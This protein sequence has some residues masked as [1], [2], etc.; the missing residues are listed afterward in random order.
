MCRDGDLA[1]IGI[2]CLIYVPL[3]EDNTIITSHRNPFECARASL[4]T[5]NRHDLG[6]S[7]TDKRPDYEYL[8]PRVLFLDQITGRSCSG[9]R[10]HRWELGQ[11]R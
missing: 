3:H 7:L 10:S 8:R 6:Q 1:C 11:Q 4:D 9:D 2:K 5:Q